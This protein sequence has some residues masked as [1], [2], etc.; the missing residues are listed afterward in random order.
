[1][2][3]WKFTAQTSISS[4][5]NGSSRLELPFHRHEME[6]HGAN[7]HFIATKWKFTA[8]TSISSPRNGSSRHELPFHRHEMEVHDPNFHFIPSKRKFTPRTSISSSSREDFFDYS[9]FGL[10]IVLYV[11]P[12]SGG[13]LPLSVFVQCT[14]GV[15]GTQPVSKC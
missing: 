4:P 1:A 10:G 6:V 12:C 9:C 2:T 11:F 3:K 7:F 8:R 14:V 13:K 5:R 15:A